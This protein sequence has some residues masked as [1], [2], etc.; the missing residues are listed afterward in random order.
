MV[1]VWT[2]LWV[3]T[4]VIL[5]YIYIYNITCKMMMTPNSTQVKGIT[6]NAYQKLVRCWIY[7]TLCLQPECSMHLLFHQPTDLKGVY[8][9]IS[10]SISISLYLFL[11]R[12]LWYHFLLLPSV[13][14]NFEHTNRD[15]DCMLDH[16]LTR[17]I[18]RQ[19]NSQVM[20]EFDDW[21][22]PWL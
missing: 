21:S 14:T 9:Y 17:G 1:N 7:W 12:T 8:I 4:I 20:R 3:H 2:L 5:I 22:T 15:K 19:I 6:E 16:I 10:I 11:I 13:S 18:K